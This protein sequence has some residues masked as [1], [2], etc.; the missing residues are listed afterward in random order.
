MCVVR[1]VWSMEDMRGWEE[2]GCRLQWAF[3]VK[4]GRLDLILRTRR[5]IER[6]QSGESWGPFKPVRK[7]DGKKN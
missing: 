4:F 7:L 2:P 3:N 6:L 5:N 1:G